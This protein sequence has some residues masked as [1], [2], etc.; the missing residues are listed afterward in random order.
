[1]LRGDPARLRQ[2]LLNLASNA[3]KFTDAGEVVIRAQVEDE[4][5]AGPVVRFE[6]TD[7]GLG[8][9]DTDRQR[10]FEPFSQADSSTTRRFGGTGLGL[11]IC[12]Q[13][14]TAMGGELGVESEL[15]R[16]ARS[17]SRCP[18]R[19]RR[20]SRLWWCRVRLR[21]WWGRGCEWWMT[22]TRTG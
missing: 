1:M 7:T 3:V 18:W 6:V 13:L 22:I 16:G 2:V 17:G 12:R 20:W 19:W 8:L 10:L 5:D 14:V 4:T 9:E 15:G 11:A 21:V